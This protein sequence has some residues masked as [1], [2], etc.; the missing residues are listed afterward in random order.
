MWVNLLIGLSVYLVFVLLRGLRGFEFY[1]ARLVGLRL[2]AAVQG[3][4]WLSCVRARCGLR[5]GLTVMPGS[6]RCS[7]C[8][9]CRASRRS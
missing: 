7:Y 5:E 8:P 3:A 1:H 9:Q 6:L 4:G 2:A